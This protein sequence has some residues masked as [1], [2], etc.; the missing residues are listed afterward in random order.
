MKMSENNGTIPQTEPLI[1]EK[2][3][4]AMHEYMESGAWLIE[5]K[6][7]EEFEKRICEF[8]G[9]KHCV[10]VNNG[11]VALTLSLL[12]AGVKHGDEFLVP[13]LTMIASANCGKLFGAEPVFVDVEEKTLCMDMDL[14][15]KAL[16]PETKALVYVSL[17]GRSGD[18]HKAKKFCDEHDLAFIEDSAQSLGSFYAGKHLGTFSDAGIFSFT[19]HK[20]ITT[21]EGGAAITNDSSIYDRLKKL[22]N[23]GR[24]RSGTDIHETIG[25]NFRF[26]DLQAVIGIEQIKTLRDRIKRKKEIYRMYR[27]ELDGTVDFLDTDLESTTPMLVDIYADDA[28]QLAPYLEKKG[29]G[30]RRVYPPIHSQ[31]A[32]SIKKR[33]PIAEEYSRRGLWLPS[34]LKLTD[35]QIMRICSIIKGYYGK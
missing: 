34:S 17:N 2:E 14:A 20:I 10:A 5:Y 29:I 6:K 1:G 32:Y 24:T 31:K 22:K 26:S 27:R 35:E 12:A 18:M 21:G 19:P 13:D 9:S 8:T 28:G 3:K 4:E 33:F 30:T 16:T 7:T 11:T 15:E 25:F 23:F